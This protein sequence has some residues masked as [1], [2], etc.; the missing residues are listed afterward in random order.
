M[1]SFSQITYT[2]FSEE[3]S[4]SL[5]INY[6]KYEKL[7]VPT[8]FNIKDVQKL[9]LSLTA[10]LQILKIVPSAGY[11]KHLSIL[12]G[13]TVG[14]LP[15]N[16]N[17][18]SQ[19]TIPTE[20]VVG[21]SLSPQYEVDK[22]RANEYMFFYD[23]IEDQALEN[24][25]KNEGNMDMVSVGIVEA[26]SLTSKGETHKNDYRGH[27]V[28]A[29]RKIYEIGEIP[30]YVQYFPELT[31]GGKLC[32]VAKTF[33]ENFLKFLTSTSFREFDEVQSM[34]ANKL[35]TEEMYRT[36]PIEV[37]ITPEENNIFGMPNLVPANVDASPS[38]ISIIEALGAKLNEL[39]ELFRNTIDPSYYEM[40]HIK[41]TV[42]EEDLRQGHSFISQKV[43]NDLIFYTNLMEYYAELHLQAICVDESH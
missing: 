17:R 42:R 23:H 8:D 40:K 27:V 32:I 37:L 39:R 19:K 14:K 7:Y 36:L 20:Y 28:Q 38:I 24:L 33:S 29:M 2:T 41:V 26:I 10:F 31:L 30:V 12:R 4:K 18:I 13:S 16:F 43:L 6:E 35:F 3:L 9:Q 34:R 11:S 22:R 21:N 15:Q 25:A 5:K 1:N